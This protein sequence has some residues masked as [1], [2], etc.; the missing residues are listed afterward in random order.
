M[1]DWLLAHLR[2]QVWHAWPTTW[3]R[4]GILPGII[5]H[6]LGLFRARGGYFTCML[7]LIIPCS[8][9]LF[10]QTGEVQHVK[11]C[12]AGAQVKRLSKTSETACII[13]SVNY[14]PKLLYGPFGKQQGCAACNNFYSKPQNLAIYGPDGH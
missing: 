5:G 12:R 1:L 8:A 10:T 14:A 3:A 9:G 11:S 4:L 6:W 13:V 2:L 7:T